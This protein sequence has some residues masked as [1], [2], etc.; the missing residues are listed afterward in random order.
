MKN[1]H[2]KDL[3]KRRNRQ[4]MYNKLQIT[5]NTHKTKYAQWI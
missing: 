5:E 1:V 3:Q 4:I 2:N